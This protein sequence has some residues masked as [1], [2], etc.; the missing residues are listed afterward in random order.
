[1]DLYIETIDAFSGYNNVLGYNVGNEVV[2]ASND[3]SPATF[4]KAA[5]RDIKAYLKSKS[6]SALVA[7][8]AIN[9]DATWLD[10]LA[11]YLSCDPSNGNSGDT[12]IDLFGLNDYEWCGN[13]ANTTYDNTNAQFAGYNVAAYFSEYGCVTTTSRVWTEVATLFASPMTDI[14]SGGIA[15]SYF[16]ATS[17]AGQFGMVTIS[18]NTVT[19][20]TDFSNLKT[21]YGQ[22]SPPNSPSQSSESN[23]Y[24]TC[25]TTNDTWA[26]STTLPPT[27]NDA[28]CQCLENE[29]SCRYTPASGENSTAIDVITGSLLD[30]TCSLLGQTGGNCNDIAANGTTGSY[31]RVSFCPPQ[32]KLS[33]VMSQYYESQNHNS[34][35]CSFSGNA[36]INTGASSASGAAG[37]AALSCLA[38][39]SATFVP[40]SPAGGPSSTGTSGKSGSASLMVNL[41]S[42]VVVLAFGTV[43]AMW[44]FMA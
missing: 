25:P 30:Y 41:Q 15:F 43:G 20:S 44:T 22:I 5:A 42:L 36:T 21:Q 13:A 33:Y 18:G 23:T 4:V 35:A 9:G 1:L 14:W 29:L 16:P 17:S 39:P 2:V 3:T 37:S 26:A 27:P 38:N 7:Y 40:S 24:P 34:Q 11:N 28:S 32:D 12:A 10:P 31:G 8:A 19:T 6:S